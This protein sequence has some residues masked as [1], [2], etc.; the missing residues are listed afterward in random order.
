MRKEDIFEKIFQLNLTGLSEKTLEM[1]F[2]FCSHSKTKENKKIILG[3]K[4]INPSSRIVLR[5]FAFGE[6]DRHEDIN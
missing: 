6:F 3:N 2:G 4:L 1:T 5:L